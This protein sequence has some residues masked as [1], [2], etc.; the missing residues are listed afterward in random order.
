[1]KSI[2]AWPES[3]LSLPS[4]KL[5]PCKTASW[6][7]KGT[8]LWDTATG[9][10]RPLAKKPNSWTGRN[11]TKTVIHRVTVPQK[12]VNYPPHEDLHAMLVKIPGSGNASHFYP[13][14]LFF[15]FCIGLILHIISTAAPGHSLVSKTQRKHASSIHVI[16][17]VNHFFCPNK[18]AQTKK[19][20][21]LRWN[22]EVN[23]TFGLKG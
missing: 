11:S 16:P 5:L 8:D 3:C 1:M 13:L 12:Q 4:D 15:F 22:E 10:Q 18:T 14:T 20:I 23:I 7:K 2:C 6:E 9:V 19:G 17:L 21:P